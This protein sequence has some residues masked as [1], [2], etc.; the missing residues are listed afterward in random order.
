MFSC[1]EA[2]IYVAKALR[3]GLK[4]VRNRFCCKLKVHIF[5]TYNEA[6]IYL[7]ES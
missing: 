2:I 3:I 4:L 1:S 7:A 6:F 5:S